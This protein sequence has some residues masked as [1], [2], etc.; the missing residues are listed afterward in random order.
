MCIKV[1]YFL[2][3]GITSVLTLTT[4]TLDCRD[5]LPK[6]QYATALDWFIIMCYVFVIGSLLEFAGVHYFTKHGSGEKL[7]LYRIESDDEE[8]ASR[9]VL[10]QSEELEDG[11]VIRNKVR[12]CSGGRGPRNLFICGKT[13]IFFI[14]VRRKIEST[15]YVH[16]RAQKYLNS[17]QLVPSE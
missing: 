14:N 15:L 4:V 2:C 7:N 6:V 17:P 1:H 9:E 11:T 12:G 16:D 5:D 3:A 10:S 8:D 13:W